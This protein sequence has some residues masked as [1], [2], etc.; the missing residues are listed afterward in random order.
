[1]ERTNLIIETD[2]LIIR[3]YAKADYK[4]WYTQYDNR[5]PS[6]YKYDDGRPSDMHFSTEEWFTEWINGFYEEALKDDTYVFG[7]FR[8]H[9]GVNVGKLEI[10]TILRK[11]Y[12]WAMMGYSIH[13]QFWKN[14]YATESVLKATE[15]FFE[16]LGY[17]RIEL[18]IN[19]DN[20]PSTR[21]AERT[22][23]HLECV[24]KEFSYEDGKWTDFVIYYKNRE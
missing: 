6:Q 17:H 5:L 16:H 10:S 15:S 20:L 4:N 23:F 13:N 9:D 24:R 3:P 1:M 21:L 18:H 14:G 11:D 22:G 2:R 19:V 8:K 12:Q 7:I